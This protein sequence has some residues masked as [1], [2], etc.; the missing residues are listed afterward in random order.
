[1]WPSAP[2]WPGV[3]GDGGA[4]DHDYPGPVARDVA[5][6]GGDELQAERDTH[7]QDLDTV[8]VAVR[9]HISAKRVVGRAKDLQ[10]GAP[11]LA[12]TDDE[13]RSVS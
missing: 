6:G 13:D 12:E 2:G 10:E 3:P 9:H 5:G 8:E 11:D 1:M 4:V 7:V